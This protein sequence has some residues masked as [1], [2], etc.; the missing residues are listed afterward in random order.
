MASENSITHLLKGV[1]H[2]VTT[3]VQNEV[4]LGRAELKAG[5]E[6]ARAGLIQLV[7]AV[8]FAIPAI[9]LLGAAAALALGEV[10]LS[11]MAGLAIVGGLLGLLTVF[12][13]L[14]ARRNVGSKH[15]RLRETTENLERDAE[16]L[17]ETLS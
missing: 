11:P 13:L 6:D 8:A 14:A 9:T 4:R 5:M 16:T 2:D 15:A 12:M 10:G 17:K 7:L 3:L 1:L